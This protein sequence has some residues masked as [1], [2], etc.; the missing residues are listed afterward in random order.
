MQLAKKSNIMI[1]LKDILHYYLGCEVEYDGILNGKE[2]RSEALANKHDVFYI[3]KVTAQEG[4]KNG[5][6]KEVRY[7]KSG[8]AVCYVGNKAKKGYWGN[9][10]NIKLVLRPL[11]DMTEEEKKEYEATRVFV[12]ATPVHQVGNMQWTPATFHYLLSKHFDLFGLIDSGQAISKST[13]TPNP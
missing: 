10:V 3:P 8:F 12:R 7:N 9:G 11:S 1:Q 4:K 2:L 13:S 5:F 6:L